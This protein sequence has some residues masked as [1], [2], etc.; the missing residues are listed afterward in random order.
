MT[1]Q[2]CNS[3]L[4]LGED[5]VFTC[6]S[7]TWKSKWRRSAECQLG[8][9]I[10][11]LTKERDEL[12][13][14]NRSANLDWAYDYTKLREMCQKVGIPQSLIDGDTYYVPHI[15]GLGELL[16]QKIEALQAK[17]ARFEEIPENTTKADLVQVCKSLTSRNCRL[18][19]LGDALL[20]RVGCGCGVDGPCKQCCEAVA[21]WEENRRD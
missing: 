9:K 7:F 16:V 2:Y 5:E 20:D 12:K 17:V 15:V 3:P 13:A 10:L 6:G 21:A 1:C 4:K 18:E 11:K 14:I 19:E 8:E